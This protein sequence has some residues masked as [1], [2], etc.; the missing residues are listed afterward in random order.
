MSSTLSLYSIVP[1]VESN[2]ACCFTF[3]VW[4]D[5]FHSDLSRHLMLEVKNKNSIMQ[6][7]VG[8]IIRSIRG[9]VDSK[10]RAK[11][12]LLAIYGGDWLASAL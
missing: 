11:A 4:F 10:S 6:N 3:F 12:L 7:V 1:L 5:F 8:H 2:R 9:T